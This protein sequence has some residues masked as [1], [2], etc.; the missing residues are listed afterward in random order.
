MSHYSEAN[1]EFLRLYALPPE[2]AGY[3]PAEF[4]ERYGDL[5]AEQ[6]A[7]DVSADYGLDR[8]DLGWRSPPPS[9]LSRLARP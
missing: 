6:A 3:G 1:A 2:D 9:F 4:A 5:P 8:V 7:F